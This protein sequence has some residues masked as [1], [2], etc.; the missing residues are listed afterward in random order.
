LLRP[1]PVDLP[2]SAE[3]LRRLG[4]VGRT[5]QPFPNDGWSGAE[6][7][8]ISRG[9]DRFVVKR[10]SLARDWIA[11]ATRDGPLL[12]EAWFAATGPSLPGPLAVPYLGV[13]RDGDDVLLVMP[14]LTGTLLPWE[15]PIDVETLDRV[16]AGMARLHAFPWPA[17]VLAAG[18]W[19]PI[20]DRLLL[21]SRPMAE[22]YLGWGGQA[23]VAA[24]RFIAGWDAFDR[25]APVAAGALIRDLAAD[26]SPLVAT[27][28]QD[29][30]SLLHGDLK[31]ANVGIAADG[32]MP[33]I[34]WQM[35]MV[36]SVAIEIGWFLVSNSANLP[37]PPTAALELYRRHARLE[38]QAMD[39]AWIVGLL[40]RGWRKGLDAEAG[41]TIPSGMSAK[42]DLAEWCAT[43]VEAARRRL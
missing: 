34:D 18:Q 6:L 33:T 29:D 9:R 39:L 35:A 21:L 13:G 24:E 19:C 5:E 14:D 11:R 27:L 32:S 43:A 1:P 42:D 3:V 25:Q 22:R 31:L 36:G 7:S 12:R 8:V 28:D 15:S 41:V 37:V 2:S 17:D 26:V 23:A 40:L 30:A 20:A 4:L 10:D 16:M 38:E